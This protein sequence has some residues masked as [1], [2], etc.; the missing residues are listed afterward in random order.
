[1]MALVLPALGL[2]SSM[3]S[4]MAVSSAAELQAQLNAAIAARAPT[5]TIPAGTYNFSTANLNVSGATSLLLVADGATALFR[6]AAGVNI[7]NCEALHVRGL[8]I[9]YE[10][11]VPHGRRGVPG[12]TYNVFNSSSVLSEDITIFRA[13]FF[14][15]TAF[16]GGGGHIFRR[17]NLPGGIVPDPGP[18]PYPHQRDAF[19]F[20]D[21]RRG[22]TLEDSVAS[23]F[24][25]DFFNSHNTIMLVLARESPS[26]LLIINPHVQNVRWRE[27]W[28][29]NT[30]YGTNSVL[31]NVGGGDT[32]SFFAP[33]NVTS[34]DSADFA[35]R[36]RSAA[37]CVVAGATER[38][39]DATVLAAASALASSFARSYGTVGFDAS[40]V[41]RVQFTVPLPHAVV[42]GSLVNVDS[43]STPGTI[44]RNNT[45]NNTRYNLGRFKSNGGRIVNNTFSRAGV[46]NLEITPLLQ[47]FEGNLPTV[48]D[49]VVEGNVI[50]GEGAFPIHCSPFCSNA[51]PYGNCSKCPDCGHDSAWAV[52]ITLSGNTVNP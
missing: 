28:W 12:I 35:P 14:A 36:P 33:V 10:S 16:N 34:V 23:D 42:Q 50:T 29:L 48:R 3:A 5:F 52:N 21:M 4:S 26:S 1:M 31:E 49:V 41:W 11:P 32:M 40:D 6:G 37:P 43:F 15:V 24:G 17:F 39:G 51:C 25:D 18:C 2:A 46:P 19:H 13:P 38:V 9:T 45:F 30:V 47:Y 22:V 7:T 8:S 44:V 20:S 27:G